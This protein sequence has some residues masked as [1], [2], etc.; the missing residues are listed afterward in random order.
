[1]PIREFVDAAGITW[2]AWE[3]QNAVARRQIQR[4]KRHLLG[5]TGEERRIRRD[6]RFRRARTP[7]AWLAFQSPTEKRRI[8]PIPQ[9]WEQAPDADLRRWCSEAVPPP[10]FID[11]VD[12]PANT[13]VI[14]ANPAPADSI[15]PDM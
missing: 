12:P 10:V 5:Y 6:R 8:T 1:M 13:E 9:G 15:Q 14:P 11:W 7:S 4:R 3:V 2:R